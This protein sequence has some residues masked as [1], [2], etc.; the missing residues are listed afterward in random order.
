MVAEYPLRIP[1]DHGQ[2]FVEDDALADVSRW[3]FDATYARLGRDHLGLKP[4]GLVVT[5]MRH[6]GDTDVVVD[7]RET[8]PD[9]PAAMWE[10]SD[11]WEH[12]VECG[13]VVASGK[14]SVFA[15]EMTGLPAIPR[16]PI[17]PGH[18]RVLVLYGALDSVVD[19]QEPDGQDHYRVVLWP[20]EPVE[21]IVRRRGFWCCLQGRH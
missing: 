14:L 15:P 17:A 12:V 10:R 3:D 21:P 9:D 5:T 20:G 16:V 8:P 19:E 4:G 1:I 6:W 13:L 7:V 11:A 2:F 18:Y